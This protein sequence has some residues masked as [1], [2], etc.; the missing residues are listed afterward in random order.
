MSPAVGSRIRTSCHPNSG[1]EQWNSYQKRDIVAR[2]SIAVVPLFA[3]LRILPVAA[4]RR[5]VRSVS[6]G[7]LICADCGAA[8]SAAPRQARRLHHKLGNRPSLFGVHSDT[9]RGY[10]DGMSAADS[11]APECRRASIRLRRPLSIGLIFAAIVAAA[12]SLHFWRVRTTTVKNGH[13]GFRCIALALANYADIWD[14]RLPSPQSS[15]AGYSWR[16]AIQPLIEGPGVAD[17]EATIPW[18]SPRYATFAAGHHPCYSFDVRDRLET[19]LVAVVGKNTAWAARNSDEPNILEPDA[20]ICIECRDS[21]I[22]WMQPGDFDVDDERALQGETVRDNSGKFR[23]GNGNG[24]IHVMFAD[25][26]VWYLSD[27]TPIDAIRKFLRLTD[28]KRYDR[29]NELKKYRIWESQTPRP[30][31]VSAR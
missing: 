20:L 29:E 15:A 10:P 30:G 5:E 6:G 25:L 14:G 21:G 28:A 3:H 12:V 7:V 17:M 11:V 1:Q 19:N 27:A 24:G 8:V 23:M 26:E 13:L 9:R 31:T 16:F 2:L 4:W 18:D 22:H